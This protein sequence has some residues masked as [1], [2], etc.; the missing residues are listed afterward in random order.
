[1]TEAEKSVMLDVDNLII[2][3]ID[4]VKVEPESFLYQE[5]EVSEDIPQS[6]LSYFQTSESRALVCEKL[7]L[8][9]LEDSCK[10]DENGLARESGRL[11]AERGRPVREE[12]QKE[13]QRKQREINFQ[14]ELKKI[15]ETEKLHQMEL[16]LIGRKA[17]EKIERELLIQQEL[18]GNLKKRVEQERKMIEEEKKSKKAEEEERK[19]KEKEDKR[20]REEED[21]RKRQEER[22]R[23]QDEEKHRAVEMRV[24]AER[25]RRK[26]EE[27]Q[28]KK[29]EGKTKKSEEQKNWREEEM[30]RKMEEERKI[31]EI[32][33]S[34]ETTRRSEEEQERKKEEEAQREEAQVFLQAIGNMMREGGKRKD[35]EKLKF[36]DGPK[37]TD[38]EES[39]TKGK[40]E[41]RRE[42]EERKN[43]HGEVKMEN[44]EMGAKEEEEQKGKAW[45][46]RKGEGTGATEKKTQLKE[47][48]EKRTIDEGRLNI[49]PNKQEA[50]TRRLTEEEDYKNTG[51]QNGLRQDMK[52]SQQ[53]KRQTEGLDIKEKREDE[54]AKHEEVKIFNKEDDKCEKV[55]E[56]RGTEAGGRRG[57]EQ[58]KGD[59]EEK[60][61]AENESLMEVPGEG[62]G[63]QDTKKEGLLTTKNLLEKKE[64]EH[65][66]LKSLR[67]GHQDSS[68]PAPSFRASNEG[69]IS[70]EETQQCP[71]DKNT[72]HTSADKTPAQ[73]DTQVTPSC[74][75]PAGLSERTEQKRLTWMKTCASWAELSLQN[76]RKQKDCVRRWRGPR[77]ADEAHSL[78]PL[79]PDTLLWMSGWKSLQEITTLTL[80]DV[81]GCSLSTLVQCDQLRSL[82]LRRCG[83]RSLEGVAQ[84]Q[85]LW[86][87]DLQ[88]NDISF[89]DCENMSCLRVIRLAHNKLASIHGLGGAEN[90]AVLDLSHNS[91]TR[92]TGLESVKRL[93]RLS[94]DHNQL[95][96]TKGLRDVYTLLHL[97][98]SHNHLATVEGLENSALLHTLDLRANSLT[99]PPVLNDQVLLRELHLDDNSIASL[100][101]LAACW[102]PLLQRVS[103]AQ[104]RITQLPSMTDFVSLEN[105]DLR[106]NCLSELQDVCEN[107]KGCCFLREVH[108]SGNPLQ[109]ESGWRSALQKAVSGLRVI[110]NQQTDSC[111]SPVAA[112][113]LGTAPDCFLTFCRAQLQQTQD[114]QQGLSRELS[115]ASSP[116]DAMK[117]HC[118]H[119]TMAL[120]LAENQR[121]AHEYGDTSM[122]DR[123]VMPDETTAEKTLD[124]HRR[125]SEIATA[126][127][128][129][130]F[131]NKPPS[132]ILSRSN[133]RCRNQSF[134]N[135]PAE[136]SCLTQ[137]DSVATGARTVTTV[138]K[139]STTCAPLLSLKEE[140]NT[141]NFD[142]PLSSHPT[143]D[144]TSRA[145]VVIQQRWRKRRQKCGAVTDPS[146][147]KRG[148]GSGGDGENSDVTPSFI[149][150]SVVSQGNAAAVIQAFWRGFTLRR[151]LASA[152]AAVT[153]PDVEEDDTFEEVDVE[154]F[155]FDEEAV[156][157]HWKV[158]ISEDSPPR[159]YVVSEQPS[160]AQPLVT[161]HV[162][163]QREL[164]PPLVWSPKQAWT[165]EQQDESGLQRMSALKSNR[166]QSPASASALRGLSERSEKILEEWGFTDS[167]TA[168]LMLKRAQKMKSAKQK[169]KKHRNPSVHAALVR[170][171]SYQ[172]SPVEARNRPA[173]HSRYCFKVGEAE[174]GLQQA[175]RT[176]R[177]SWQSGGAA[178]ADRHS[179]SEHFLPEINS[180]ILGRGRVQLVADTANIDRP[181][182]ARL[183]ADSTACKGNRYPYRNALPHT[184][185]ET[186][187]PWRVTSAASK[188]ERISFRD[189]P[190]QLSGGWGGGKKRDRS[191]SYSHK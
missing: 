31:Q 157:K 78:P 130:E 179:K 22:K 42:E 91:I 95:I 65:D 54:D 104:N 50:E 189:N 71:S 181:H 32:S 16:E 86:Y 66:N 114:L 57:E 143:L 131:N 108:L 148:G 17:Q 4:E 35:E 99:E 109:Q 190:V 127:P 111:V 112:R 20:K 182:S 70:S 106:F 48:E 113:Q 102:L 124:V 186:P 11:E 25:G 169:Q 101:G 76:R 36:K 44:E 144:L 171:S 88:E 6:L 61:R 74:S 116:L 121:F 128:K 30:K 136:E 145:A 164:Q 133:I 122:A 92:I 160:A 146:I 83:L 60:T 1:M 150:R 75:S 134:E 141:L 43:T 175:D 184:N 149:N 161:S 9:E 3:D 40:K 23:M 172:L 69:H 46:G 89:V 15:M 125:S 93:Q 155:V 49:H 176:E 85:E 84:L 68:R 118:H 26:R 151:R 163:S 7:I 183:C 103:V 170:N 47:G 166:S 10:E 167:R 177:M 34:G 51:D 41:K 45:T 180:S 117:T 72:C 119:F 39:E 185:E 52:N 79:S 137:F 162:D 153:C 188:K 77:R 73:Q 14:A 63:E 33:V 110:D 168:L 82:T 18:I 187:S 152:L 174:L 115:N 100:R 178:Q 97:D 55:D 94:V 135:T 29:E 64:G 147:T 191:K 105:L 159:R 129:P 12:L 62:E 165:A 27:E 96:S 80:E 158:T 132:V 154:E 173:Q 90:L 5:E 37:K 24:K 58:V 21:K 107:L 139:A 19:T 2:S 126:D 28:K 56:T 98:C 81:P 8:E 123:Q 120:Q 156:E 53:H 38:E 59:E 87:I 138:S 142:K 67:S 13:E 140:R